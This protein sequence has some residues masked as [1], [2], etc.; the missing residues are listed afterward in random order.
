[1]QEHLSMQQELAAH[2][3]A[4]VKASMASYRTTRVQGRPAPAGL[5]LLPVLAPHPA[6]PGEVV[7][8]D[9]YHGHG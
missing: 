7:R 1:M 5:G 8:R 3:P 4:L 9:A 2:A 6:Q